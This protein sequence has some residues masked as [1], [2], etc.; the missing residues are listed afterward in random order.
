M[1]VSIDWTAL[2][3]VFLVSFAAGVGLIVLFSLGI[4]AL[5]TTTETSQSS[6]SDPTGGKAASRPTLISPVAVLCFLACALIVAYGLYLIII[7]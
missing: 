7:K 6:P 3:E 1:N 2:G 5:A 4:N